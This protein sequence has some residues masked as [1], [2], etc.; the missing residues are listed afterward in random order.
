MKPA[1]NSKI[2][3]DEESTQAWLFLIASSRFSKLSD[4]FKSFWTKVRE[5]RK[6]QNR[7]ETLK[8]FVLGDVCSVIQFYGTMRNEQVS[9]DLLVKVLEDVS[10][11]LRLA[12]LKVES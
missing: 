10:D 9:D 6:E 8:L 4:L 3:A 11:E 7:F 1:D 5:T 2:G 12:S